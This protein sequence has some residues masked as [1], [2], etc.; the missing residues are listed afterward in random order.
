MATKKLQKDEKT[1][2]KPARKS[3]AKKTTE[4]IDIKALEVTQADLAWC[5]GITTANITGFCQT[6]LMAK[7][8]NGKYNLVE[9]VSAYCKN[10]RERKVGSSKSDIDTET[11][12]W[13]LQNIKAKNR[14]WRMQRD[15]E[16]ALEIVRTL[17]NAMM[18]FREMAK[19]NPALVEAIDGMLSKIGSVNVDSISLAVEGETEEEE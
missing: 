18:E 17:T 2:E 14:D 13:K 1:V 8:A 6:G 15:R 16:V 5:L 4:K 19:L 11:A 12:S 3:T 10:L 7:N 9:C